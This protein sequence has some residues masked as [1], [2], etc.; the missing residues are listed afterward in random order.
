MGDDSLADKIGGFATDA[1]ADTAADGAINSAIDG[2]AADIPGGSAMDGVLKT[3]VDLAA[4]NAINGELGRLEG[5]FR[6]H[7]ADAAPATAPADA[8]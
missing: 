4:N 5:M 3:G 1:T 8:N 7:P 2:I 6:Q